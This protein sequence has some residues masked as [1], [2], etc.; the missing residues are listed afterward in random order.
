MRTGKRKYDTEVVR[1]LYAED[2][3]INQVVVR[4]LLAEEGHE[5]TLASD[6]SECLRLLDLQAFD[7]VFMDLEMEPMGG[8][9][10]AARIRQS[11]KGFSRIPIVALTQHEAKD[12]V[13]GSR[14]A[15]M[16]A[17]LV[18]PIKVPALLAVMAKLLYTPPDG[19]PDQGRGKTSA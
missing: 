6:G 13:E 10:A 11:G 17:Y 1:L 18:K 3:K 15:G 12:Y 19:A 16:D 5:V 8:I 4:G 9:E 14:A 2:N 7:I